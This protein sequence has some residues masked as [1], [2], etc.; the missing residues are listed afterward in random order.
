M[1]GQVDGAFFKELV[2]GRGDGVPSHCVLLWDVEVNPSANK[3]K[4][5]VKSSSRVP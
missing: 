1:D 2:R 5:G 3:S 4:E